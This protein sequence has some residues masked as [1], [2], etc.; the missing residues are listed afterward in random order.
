M[1]PTALLSTTKQLDYITREPSQVNSWELM[2]IEISTLLSLTESQYQEICN[3]YETLQKILNSSTEAVLQEAH[4]FVQG[5]IGLKTTIKPAKG[6]VDD[7][8]TIDA[9]AIILLPNVDDTS[10]IDVLK[11]IER[12][13]RAAT[14]VEAPIEPL[15][16]G[17]RIVYAD[18]DPGF[19]MDITPARLAKGNTNSEGYGFLEVPDREIGWKASSPRTY[20]VW[21]DNISKTNISFVLDSAEI[22]ASLTHFAEATQEPLPEYDSYA[23][24]NPLRV[25]IKLIKRNRDEWAL[26]HRLKNY[27]PISAVLTTLAAKAYEE[28]VNES[29]TQKIRPLEAIF[30]IINRMPKFIDIK[31]GQ[32]RVENPVDSG[33]NFAEK[34]NR[35]HGEGEKYQQAFSEWYAAAKSAFNLGFEVQ[36]SSAQF[37]EKL[38][39]SF[40][41]PYSRVKDIVNSMPRSWTLP[42]REKGISLNSLSKSALLGAGAVTTNSQ[43]EVKTVERFG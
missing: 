11:I 1:N 7:M 4:I 42:G 21:L 38:S 18:E 23:D 15:R 43:A 12:R 32:F 31:Y 16:R 33:E 14:R 28:I 20:S 39:Q 41:I 30:L 6:A 25:A 3:R 27:R 2:L 26:N 9:D 29:K 36:S 37:E 8:A 35:P 17:I 24:S 10:A 34:W 19:H 22:R 5:S 13:F 40:G